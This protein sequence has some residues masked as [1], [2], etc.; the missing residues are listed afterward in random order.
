VHL[1]EVPTAQWAA[2]VVGEEAEV[3]AAAHRS[4]K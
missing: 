4:S 2:L 1:A 3:A